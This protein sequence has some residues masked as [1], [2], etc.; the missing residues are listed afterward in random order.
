MFIK[1][2]FVT[3]C[4]ATF[5][6]V[7]IFLVFFFTSFI[8]LDSAIHQATSEEHGKTQNHDLVKM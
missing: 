8:N 6:D 3:L 5:K 4:I 1:L 2:Y 7:D